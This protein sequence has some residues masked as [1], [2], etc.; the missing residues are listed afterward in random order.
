M[1]EPR[2][3]GPRGVRIVANWTTGVDPIFAGFRARTGGDA[4]MDRQRSNRLNIY[5]APIS[6]TFDAQ[7]TQW[8]AALSLNELWEQPAAGVVI[9]HKRTATGALVASVCRRTPA[10]RE[11]RTSCRAGKDNDCNGLVG[12][13]DPA[14][15]R[16]LASKR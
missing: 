10:G 11:T 8:R 12:V 2:L 5:Q 16:L 15:A 3:T 4:G 9:R 1:N 6:H 14:C 7:P 13:A